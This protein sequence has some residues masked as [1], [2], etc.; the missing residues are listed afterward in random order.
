MFKV[1]F[2]IV[3]PHLWNKFPMT[4]QNRNIQSEI[5]SERYFKD[6]CVLFQNEENW[7]R[8]NRQITWC[9]MRYYL[10]EKRKILQ[11]LLCFISEWRK[12]ISHQT[13]KSRDVKWDMYE[14]ENVILSTAPTELET[15]IQKIWIFRIGMLLIDLLTINIDIF[16]L[17][18]K[19]YGAVK[20]I[21]RYL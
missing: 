8:F 17:L 15:Y 7:Y 4:I 1:L 20:C 11:G 9:K 6:F 13:D 18:V 12:L 21:C 5:A 16:L 14:T 2:R 19:E 3:S 10:T